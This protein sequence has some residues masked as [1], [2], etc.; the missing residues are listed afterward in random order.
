M[1]V[2]QVFTITG[3]YLL[4]VSEQK[5]REDYN[6]KRKCITTIKVIIKFTKKKGVAML[7][8]NQV[9]QIPRSGTEIGTVRAPICCSNANT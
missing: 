7:Q 2:E 5:K 9:T 4:K 3:N 8:Y 6:K 1:I